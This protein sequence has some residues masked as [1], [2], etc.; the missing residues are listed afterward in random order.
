MDPQV[1]AS[2]QN[3]NCSDGDFGLQLANLVA[4][5]QGLL[6]A[7]TFS[8]SVSGFAT[9]RDYER[10]WSLRCLPFAARNSIAVS[11]SRRPLD[12]HLIIIEPIAKRNDTES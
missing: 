1:S 10:T 11:H 5:H 3:I 12:G 2:R 7:H 9:G 4:L 6:F 8:K